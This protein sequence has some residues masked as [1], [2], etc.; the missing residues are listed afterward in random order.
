MRGRV[1]CEKAR[2]TVGSVCVVGGEHGIRPSKL[3]KDFALTLR[4]MKS[5]Q[6]ALNKG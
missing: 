3:C 4:E 6:I 2:Q 5:H 1:A